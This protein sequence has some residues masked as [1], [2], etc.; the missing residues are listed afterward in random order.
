MKFIERENEI[1]RAL[2]KL[3]GSELDFIVVGGYAVSG[4]TRH[5]FSVD[6]DIVVQK[7]DLER[8]EAVL[9]EADFTKHVEKA[10]F[11]EVYGG[12]FISYKRDVN[13]LPVTVDLLVGALFCRATEAAWSFD[14]IK[15]HSV[16]AAI[17]GIEASVSCRIP[18]RELLIALK[19]HSARRADIR[20]IVMLRE[21][22]DP[23]RILKHLKRG[24][25]EALR[26][27]ISK[28]IEAL[29]DP[30]LVDSLKDV[31]AMSIDVKKQIRDVRKDL[32]FV[33]RKVS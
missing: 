25:A 30:N 7:K 5:R 10:G 11:D 13:K 29:D 2:K 23:E 14:Y 19:I 20:D 28:I 17:S 27:Q 26:G 22:A 18:E 12:E 31:F 33:A 6:C 16:I 15:E 21:D 4:L 24:R 1:L 3:I 8:L 32:E 9:E